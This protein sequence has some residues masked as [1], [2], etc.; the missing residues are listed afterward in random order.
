MIF[1]FATAC[2]RHD[3]KYRVW[4]IIG[5]ICIH[6]TNRIDV[7][8]SYIFTTL[9]LYYYFFLFVCKGKWEVFLVLSSFLMLFIYY[10]EHFLIVIW[11]L[12]I[13]TLKNWIHCMSWV[14]H[15][16]NLITSII[17]RMINLFIIR[18]DSSFIFLNTL[19]FI[20][21]IRIQGSMILY[22]NFFSI[23]WWSSDFL[24]Q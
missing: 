8:I 23:D 21:L 11:L 13:N 16:Y 20:M 1:W 2:T 19:I 17:C 7:D 6:H 15:L 24:H 4:K 5:S 12:K 18:I 22:L 3:I 9:T 10:I 14:I